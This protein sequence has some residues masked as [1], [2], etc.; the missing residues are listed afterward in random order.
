MFSTATYIRRRQQLIHNINT[1]GILLFLTNTENPINFE[2]NCYPFRQDSSFLY[3]FG[4]KPA[5]IFAAID[6]DANETI[7]FGDEASI[8]DIGWT[9]RLE[10]LHD[11]ATKTSVEKILPSKEVH[12]IC[13]NATAQNRTIHSLPPYQ[14][15]NR[16]LL[17][18]LTQTQIPN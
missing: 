13:Q 9:G 4:I 14:G 10:T 11:K 17:A 1:K 6:L 3:Y 18:E 5:G 16:S 2:H 7:T 8:D 12:T 15:Y